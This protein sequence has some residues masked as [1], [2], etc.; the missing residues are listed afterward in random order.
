MILII[1]KP[2]GTLKQLSKHA[3]GDS[4]IYNVLPYVIAA[5]Q[6]SFM[7]KNDLDL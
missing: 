4:Y 5:L 1:I 6:Y 2:K 7:L 3:D